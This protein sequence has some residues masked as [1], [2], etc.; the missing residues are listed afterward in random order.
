MAWILNPVRLADMRLI[1]FT[2][3][4]AAS[5]RALLTPVA[6]S[7]SIAGHKVSMVCHSRHVSSVSEAP[8]RQPKSTSQWR[9]CLNLD[10]AT[11]QPPNGVEHLVAGQVEDHA[12]SLTPR[13]HS[14]NTARGPSSMDA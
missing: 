8:T 14:L 4:F 12:R 13:A 5:M 7:T 11:A 9:A 6:V 1:C 3:V 10:P 2:L